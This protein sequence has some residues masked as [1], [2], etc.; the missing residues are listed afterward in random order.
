MAEAKAGQQDAQQDEQLDD[1]Q[2]DD[3][4]QDGAEG[5][6]GEEKQ[7]RQAERTY[8]QAE[9]D[10]IL[11]KVR[12]NARYLGRKEAEAELRAQGATATQARETVD[13]QQQQ[14]TSRRRRPKREDFENY[15][16]FLDAKADHAARAGKPRG[17]GERGEKR[18]RERVNRAAQ[19]TEREFEARRGGDEGDPGLRR[20]DRIGRERDDHRGDGR[21]DQGGRRNRAAHPLPPRAE[22]GRG[23]PHLAA[24]VGQARRPRNRKAR[25]SHRSRARR[26]AKKGKDKDD[27]EEAGDDEAGDDDK[28]G[29]ELDESEADGKGKDAERRADGTF[30]PAKKRAAPEPIEPGTARGATGSRLPS[31][32][33]DINTWMRKEEERERREGRR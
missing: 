10:R 6:G 28:G 11:G 22:P 18:A 7:Q 30:K 1:E 26:C 32:K 23:R 25:G 2:K 9:L 12:K 21:G 31:D 14:Q 3:G 19:K 20:D 16:D 24:Q 4:Q 5:E 33:D 13:R 27:Q 15:E 29:D 8:T 17:A